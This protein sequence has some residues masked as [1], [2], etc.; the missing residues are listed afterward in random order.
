MMKLAMVGSVLV[1]LAGASATRGAWGQDQTK[2]QG[3]YPYAGMGN[4]P[5]PNLGWMDVLFPHDRLS[6]GGDRNFL[7]TRRGRYRVFDDQGRQ[8]REVVD[9][10]GMGKPAGVSLPPGRYL[11]KIESPNANEFEPNFWASVAANHRTVV[12][13]TKLRESH[14]TPPATQETVPGAAR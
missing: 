7:D 1:T 9:L 5:D 12:D 2:P 3:S 11:V 6:G 14:P 8:V 4:V 13:A 10:S